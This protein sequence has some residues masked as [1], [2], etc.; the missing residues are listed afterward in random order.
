MKKHVLT[1]LRRYWLLWTPLA[2]ALACIIFYQPL[3][4]MEKLIAD[5]IFFCPL[6]EMTGL[7]CPGCGGTRSVTALLHGHPLLAFHENPAVPLL[8]L[9]F[10][11][12][13]LEA[14]CKQFG[15]RVQLY[16]RSLPFWCTAIGLLIVWNIGRNFIPALMP[17]LPVYTPS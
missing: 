9:F 11:L 14:V 5:Y 15:K 3:L 13:Y 17:M 1:R 2:V 8:L 4:A 6:Y 7:Y 16:P 12:L 10:L